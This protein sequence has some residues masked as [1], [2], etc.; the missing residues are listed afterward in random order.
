MN[1]CHQDRHCNDPIL[2]E[3]GFLCSAFKKLL[4]FLFSLYVIPS[5][6]PVHSALAAA[7][8]FTLACLPHSI[9]A[10]KA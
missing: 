8:W 3:T 2:S 10:I 9:A 7:D 5:P 4:S 1:K 6:N